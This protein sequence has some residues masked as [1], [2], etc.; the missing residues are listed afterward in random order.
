MFQRFGLQIYRIAQVLIKCGWVSPEKVWWLLERSRQIDKWADEKGVSAEKECA[1]ALE[2]AGLRRNV[3][4]ITQ[5]EL[6]DVRN[7]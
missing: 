7:F 2:F 5:D 6:V 3:Q 1:R 4:Y